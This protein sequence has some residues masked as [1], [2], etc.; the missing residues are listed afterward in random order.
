M[1]LPKPIKGIF[2]YEL[3][4]WF[5]VF[6]WQ[7]D[8]SYERNW[9]TD[10]LI[11]WGRFFVW[12]DSV[13]FHNKYKFIKRGLRLYKTILAVVELEKNGFSIHHSS[14]DPKD[15]YINLEIFRFCWNNKP[16]DRFPD[17]DRIQNSCYQVID[18]KSKKL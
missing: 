13:G 12:W 11:N 3:Q 10:D 14:S 16:I 6:M 2:F 17:I 7:H 9:K 5:F 1:N 8:K 4:I 15:R 18:G